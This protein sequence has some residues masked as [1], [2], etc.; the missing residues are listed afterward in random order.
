MKNNEIKIKNETSSLSE[1]VKRPIASDQEVEAFE[2]YAENEVKE[3]EIKDSLA[4]I[5]QDDNGNKVDVKKMVI[6]KKRGLLFNLFIFIIMLFVFGSAIYGAYN[7]IYLKIFSSKLSVSLAFEAKKEVA[8]GEEFYYNLSYKNEDKVSIN[9]LEI[10]VKYPDNFIFIASDPE[11]DKNNDSWRIAGLN[12]RRSDVIQIKGKLVGPAG[13]GHIIL[14]DLTYTPE[15]FSSEFRKSASYET[16]IND[17]GLDFSF[18]NSSSAL[19][20]EDNEAIVKF[21][22]KAENY[23]D[24]SAIAES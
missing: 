22:A 14:A 23:L 11:P 19:V 7:Y 1:F 12:A 17:L 21:K 2:A 13:S 3:E 10:K 9:N 18:I 20:N 8:A 5:Y 6:K 15:N 4:E 16:K 24:N